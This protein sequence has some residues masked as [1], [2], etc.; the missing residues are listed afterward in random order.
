MMIGQIHI[1]KIVNSVNDKIYVGITS[2]GLVLRWKEHVKHA[3]RLRRKGAFQGAILKYGEEVFTMALLETVETE[4][5]ACD[6]ERR[7]IALLNSKWP[8]GYNMS[9]GGERRGGFRWSDETKAKMRAAALGRRNS[10]SAKMKMSATLRDKWQND[11]EFRATMTAALSTERCIAARVESGRRTGLKYGGQMLGKKHTES[12]LKKM[13]EGHK[14][15]TAWNKGIPASQESIARLVASHV[16]KPSHRRGAKASAETR[17]LMS[18]AAKGHR[19]TEETKR[20]IGE[21]SRQ[22]KASPETRTKMSRAQKGKYVSEET[23]AKLRA[24]MLADPLR[25]ERAKA[26]VVARKAKQSSILEGVPA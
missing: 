19:H 15:K 21:A 14:G 1:Y 22:R 12:A 18:T 13:S 11:P 24:S 5:A 2:R 17:A 16:G 10:E 26:A 6:A 20:I 9:D 8:N 25:F 23:K 7:Y 4:D 3:V